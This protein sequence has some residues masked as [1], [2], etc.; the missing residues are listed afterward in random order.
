MCEGF[1]WNK[2]ATVQSPRIPARI[3]LPNSSIS[4]PKQ[5]QWQWWVMKRVQPRLHFIPIY[6]SEDKRYGTNNRFSASSNPLIKHLEH[7]IPLSI[8]IPFHFIHLETIFFFKEL[9]NQYSAT[10][11][12][13]VKWFRAISYHNSNVLICSFCEFV[14][15]NCPCVLVHL[16]V[17]C[18]YIRGNHVF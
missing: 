4:S 9:Q 15:W 18:G 5:K 7:D 12:V 1:H 10:L 2:K 17:H 8:M 11:K 13:A 6:R 14:L 3:K 16:H